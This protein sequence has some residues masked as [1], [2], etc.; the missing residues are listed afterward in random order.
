M[1]SLLQELL[2]IEQRCA[3]LFN[4]GNLDEILEYFDDAI[5]GFSST[6]L[7]R[8]VG[9]T[10]LQNTFEYY[11]KEADRLEYKIHDPHLIELGDSAVLDFQWSVTLF[12]G[13]H[14]KVIPGRGTHVYIKRDGAWKIIY[15]HF[16]R[17]H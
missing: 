13:E 5:C 8:F 10:A 1:S 15:E 14:E 3:N 12:A 6:Q 2:G 4:Q 16:S 9:K 17:A 11:R 7:Q